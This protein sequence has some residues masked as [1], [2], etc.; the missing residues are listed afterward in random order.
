MD[1]VQI[2]CPPKEGVLTELLLDT[3]LWGGFGLVGYRPSPVARTPL[4]RLDHLL[5]TQLA[6]QVEMVALQPYRLEKRQWWRLQHEDQRSGD[7][8]GTA[9]LGGSGHSDT[10]IRAAGRRGW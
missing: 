7:L 6:L 8:Q 4:E 10:A 5:T 3:M 9:S 1:E 2:F